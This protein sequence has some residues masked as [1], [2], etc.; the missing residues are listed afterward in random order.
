[1]SVDF[2][3]FIFQKTLQNY[4]NYVDKKGHSFTVPDEYV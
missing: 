2:K 1:M 4:V 3:D